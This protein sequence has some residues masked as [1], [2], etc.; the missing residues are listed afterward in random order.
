MSK[1]KGC[2]HKIHTTCPAYIIIFYFVEKNRS[3]FFFELQK[4]S[5]DEVLNYVIL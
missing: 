3:S 2:V 5:R 4:L 1:Q